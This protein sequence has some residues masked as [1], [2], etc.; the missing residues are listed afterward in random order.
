MFRSFLIETTD[1]TQVMGMDDEINA[2]A[3]KIDI[4]EF[5]YFDKSHEGFVYGRYQ[6][7]AVETG[8]INRVHLETWSFKIK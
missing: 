8:E 3:E 2:T 1:S 7:K 6:I 5:Q 4:D